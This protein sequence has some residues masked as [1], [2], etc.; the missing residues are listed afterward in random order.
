[1]ERQVRGALEV[2]QWADRLAEMEPSGRHT[3]VDEAMVE[4][5]FCRCTRN[6]QNF[7]EELLKDRDPSISLRPIFPSR[8]FDFP[9]SEKNYLGLMLC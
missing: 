4:A 8:S 2:K 6:G 3:G 7:S 5:G 9:C 1:M